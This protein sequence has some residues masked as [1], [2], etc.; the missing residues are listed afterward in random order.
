MRGQLNIRENEAVQTRGEREGRAFA[1]TK[2]NSNTPWPEGTRTSVT[3]GKW[4]EERQR[5]MVGAF[6]RLVRRAA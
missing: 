6:D 4:N 3:Y 5:E 2:A 1:K